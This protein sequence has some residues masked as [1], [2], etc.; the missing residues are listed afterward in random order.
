M[1]WVSTLLHHKGALSGNRI[2]EEYV[3]DQSVT[4]GTLKSKSH[5]KGRILPLMEVEGKVVKTRS[6]DI[7]QYKRSGWKVIPNKAFK[8]TAPHLLMEMDP[9]P[10]LNR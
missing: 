3:R 8:R 2:W 1:L 4:E 5:L 7:P 6:I 10:E 9:V